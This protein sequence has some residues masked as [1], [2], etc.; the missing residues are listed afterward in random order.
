MAWRKRYGRQQDFVMLLQEGIAL[1]TDRRVGRQSLRVFLALLSYMEWHG[2]VRVS[3]VE[4]GQILSMSPQNV[5]DA[6]ERLIAHGLLLRDKKIGALATYRISALI[7]HRGRYADLH[8]AQRQA[9]AQQRL[10]ALSEAL[11][12]GEHLDITAILPAHTAAGSE[13][14]V[15]FPRGADT[16]PGGA[17]GAARVPLG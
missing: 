5:H 10:E 3:Q 15:S 12:A 8:M 13:P 6:I 17:R 2:L 11:H 4:I 9:E 14:P 7:A 16:R 1:L